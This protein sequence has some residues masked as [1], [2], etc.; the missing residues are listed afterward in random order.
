MTEPLHGG[1]GEPRPLRHWIRARPLEDQ[2]VTLAA[3]FTTPAPAAV[4]AALP[5]P[6]A[7]PD[8]QARTQACRT[9][10]VAC[11]T[12]LR[13][14]ETGEARHMLGQARL[15]DWFWIRAWY[16]GLIALA[17]GDTPA[18][19]E[20]FRAVRDALQIGRAHV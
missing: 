14:G 18:A 4:A 17:D 2:G 3:P 12:A 6:L 8:D 19:S 16:S 11:R 15:P 7:D 1:L 10:L 9:W 13:R 20:F 5:A